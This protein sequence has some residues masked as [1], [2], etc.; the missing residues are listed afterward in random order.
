MQEAGPVS[1]QGHSKLGAGSRPR[2]AS[3]DRR[4]RGLEGL[5]PWRRLAFL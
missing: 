5:F 4:A 3:G 2:G 1:R